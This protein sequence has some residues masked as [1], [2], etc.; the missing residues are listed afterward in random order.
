VADV[1]P[2]E[3]RGAAY[4]LRQSLDTV[5]AFA[6]P[7]LAMVFAA[8]LHS[9]LRTV[10]WIAVAPAFLSIAVLWIG[11]DEP[12][13]VTR[14]AGE[15]KRLQWKLD[16]LPRAFWVLC[17]VASVFMLSRFSEAF[18]VLVGLRSGLP[19]PMAPLGL[20][21]MNLAYLLSAY[22][23]G[24][25]ADRRPRQY[26]LMVG[27]VILAAANGVLAIA[28]HPALLVIGAALWGLHMGF[29]EGVFTAMVADVA[30]KHLR[31]TAFG[32]FN[33]LRGVLLLIASIAAGLLWDRVGAY[34]TFTFASVLALLTIV[35]V[36]FVHAGKPDKTQPP[37]ASPAT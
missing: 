3:Q 10:F 20:V 14:N 23:V 28:T 18:L 34:A 25:M 13:S 6:G 33:L 11:V 21:A 9:E 30:P 37:A 31:G 32:V 15:A 4:G 36:R 8:V 22:P 16:E 1:T 5:G 29:T 24:K 19:L 27:C 35:A 12:S 2:R 7:L 17:A 26:L